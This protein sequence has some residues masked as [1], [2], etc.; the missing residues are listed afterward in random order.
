MKVQVKV[1]DPIHITDV[2]EDVTINPKNVRH[3]NHQLQQFFN[4]E[5]L[6]K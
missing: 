4:Q 3:L 6:K 2:L 5:L 1:L